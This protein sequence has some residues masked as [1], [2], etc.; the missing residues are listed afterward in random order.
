[1]A[2]ST[3]QTSRH[4]SSDGPPVNGSSAANNS[5]WPGP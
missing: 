3:T 2:T 5:G 1:V 4:T